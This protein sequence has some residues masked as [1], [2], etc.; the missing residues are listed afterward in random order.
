MQ[1]LTHIDSIVRVWENSTEAQGMQLLYTV[2]YDWR[3]DLWEQ[4]QRMADMVD[5]VLEETGCKPIIVAH[6]FGGLVTYNAIAR[7]GKATADK[8]HGVLYGGT[9]VQPSASVI[10]GACAGAPP[11]SLHVA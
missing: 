6:S 11:A 10:A 3:R 2:A 1:S 7:F 5:F 4:A 9:P 8:I